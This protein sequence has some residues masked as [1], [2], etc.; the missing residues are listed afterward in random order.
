MYL[1]ALITKKQQLWWC[2]SFSLENKR[3]RNFE[4]KK[5]GVPNI[6]QKNFFHL[7]NVCSLVYKT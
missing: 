4:L 6:S 5:G 7:R 3:K 2:I 1:E